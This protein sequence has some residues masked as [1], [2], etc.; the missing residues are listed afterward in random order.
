LNSFRY[1]TLYNIDDIHDRKFLYGDLTLESG[2][3]L[4]IDFQRKLVESYDINR[5]LV[6]RINVAI[7]L[8]KVFKTERIA[9]TKQPDNKKIEKPDLLDKSNIKGTELSSFDG[10]E[11]F[12]KRMLHDIN[13]PMLEGNEKK[14]FIDI[15]K[16]L[17][18]QLKKYEQDNP[19]L[20]SSQSI[21][22]TIKKPKS[23]ASMEITEIVEEKI[24]VIENTFEN[25]SPKDKKYDSKIFKQML[26]NEP[27]LRNKIWQVIEN[28]LG[29]VEKSIFNETMKTIKTYSSERKIIRRRKLL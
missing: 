23:D 2:T 15:I 9:K 13:L 3:P 14:I 26:L 24:K 17:T 5:K 16:E 8:L 28:K 20:F 18:S 27:E 19:E 10:I 21:G 22:M 7:N 29:A 6:V 12:L 25:S 1:L 4:K 11:L